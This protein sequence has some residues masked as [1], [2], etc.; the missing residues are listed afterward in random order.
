MR[1]QPINRREK[2]APA[3]TIDLRGFSMTS[4]PDTTASRQSSVPDATLS[5]PTTRHEA[6]RD[7]FV[8]NKEARLA[9][10]ADLIG[11]WARHGITAGEIAARTLAL[12]EKACRETGPDAFV[13]E[14]RQRADDIAEFAVDRY[15]E[16]REAE[17]QQQLRRAWGRMRREADDTLEREAPRVEGASPRGPP[18]P[19]CAAHAQGGGR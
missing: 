19:P 18:A 11:D 14:L 4:I 8:H 9:A 2:V 17:R 3:K 6:L 1:H 10:L 13:T 5:P 15:G 7:A 12:C 16:L